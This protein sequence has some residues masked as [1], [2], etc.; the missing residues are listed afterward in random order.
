MACSGSNMVSVA[1]MRFLMSLMQLLIV[2]KAFRVSSGLVGS[3]CMQKRFK[4]L[5]KK[6]LSHSP[7]HCRLNLAASFGGK[8]ENVD[9]SVAQTFVSSKISAHVCK[10]ASKRFEGTRVCL[11]Y[12]SEH[13]HLM[14]SVCRKILEA[15]GLL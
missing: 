13:H 7:K 8:A 14:D 5:A 4:L 6:P 15:Q 1:S 11:Q 10:A 9:C 2:T 3:S 12:S